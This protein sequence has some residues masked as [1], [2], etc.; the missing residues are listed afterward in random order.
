MITSIVKSFF[1]FLGTIFTIS[2]IQWLSIEFYTYF[3]HDNTLLGFVK[4]MF[5]MGSPVCVFV[6]NIQTALMNHYI[7]IWA[8]AATSIIAFFF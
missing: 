2:T 8:G 6:N 7:L 3:C 1:V 5:Y 4:N